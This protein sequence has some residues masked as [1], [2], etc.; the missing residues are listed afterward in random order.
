MTVSASDGTAPMCGSQE[1]DAQEQGAQDG[2]H[3]DQRD[4]GIAAARFLEGRDA[5]GDGLDAGQGGGAAG[6]RAQDQEER[7]CCDCMAHFCSRRVDL[8][9][10]PGCRSHSTK[11]PDPDRQEHHDEEE[12]G[13][14]G[15]VSARLLALRAG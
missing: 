5:V 14:D 3:P 10:G 12:V 4:A 6:E 11:D 7:D 1:R 9:P 15:K 2:R 8:R 13:R